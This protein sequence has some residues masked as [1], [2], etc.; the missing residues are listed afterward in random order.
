ME[1]GEES[2][3]SARGRRQ[4]FLS[5]CLT[6]GPAWDTS[7]GPPHCCH[8]DPRPSVSC[9]CLSEW[10]IGGVQGRQRPCGEQD[11]LA[12]LRPTG[13]PNTTSCPSCDNIPS[14]HPLR[15]PKAIEA[16]N[17]SRSLSF[18]QAK[19]GVR[20]SPTLGQLSGPQDPCLAQ[21][22]PHPWIQP[23]GSSTPARIDDRRW[24]AGL[25]HVGPG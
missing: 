6:A 19:L 13:A 12:P 7:R 23:S 24:G 17:P 14:P 2:Q 16:G 22:V 8:L 10:A 20:R 25:G 18:N 11:S 9:P 5:A 4:H 21:S 3:G 1:M 15:R